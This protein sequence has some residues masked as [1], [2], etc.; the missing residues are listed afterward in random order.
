MKA[1]KAYLEKEKPDQVEAFEKGAQVFA[2]KIVGNFKDYEFV[3]STALAADFPFVLKS[4]CFVRFYS[5]RARRWTLM[6]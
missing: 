6:A 4:S 1:V 3:R 2:K 5:T